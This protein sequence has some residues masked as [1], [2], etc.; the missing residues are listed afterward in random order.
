MRY[1]ILIV[2]AVYNYMRIVLPVIRL[3][4]AP[5]LQ[6]FV[7]LFFFLHAHIKFVTSREFYLP[8]HIYIY[9]SFEVFYVF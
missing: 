4:H 1:V 3:I 2:A 6:S 7:Y 5:V 8:V 9:A